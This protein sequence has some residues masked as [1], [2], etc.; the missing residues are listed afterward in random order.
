MKI[1]REMPISKIVQE[2]PQ[3]AEIFMKH[4]MGCFGCAIAR[5]ES[6]AEGA[7]A[8]NINVDD[9]LKDLNKIIAE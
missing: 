1:T 2:H 8:H 3:T 5:Y 4:G 7:A 6:L 9:L